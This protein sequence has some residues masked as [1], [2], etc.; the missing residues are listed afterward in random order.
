MYMNELEGCRS[1]EPAVLCWWL[2]AHNVGKQAGKQQSRLR[3]RQSR[4]ASGHSC[5]ASPPLPPSPGFASGCLLI[6]A[7][8]PRVTLAPASCSGVSVSPNAK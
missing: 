6:R 2:V 8:A 1:A 3:R 7:T 4:W 5:L